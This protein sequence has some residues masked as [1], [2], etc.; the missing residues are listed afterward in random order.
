MYLRGARRVHTCP[1]RPLCEW[2][3]V[4]CK[5]VLARVDEGDYLFAALACRAFRNALWDLHPLKYINNRTIALPRFTTKALALACSHGRLRW[6]HALG[7]SGPMWLQQTW[8]HENGGRIGLEAVCRGESVMALEFVRC[9]VPVSVWLSACELAALGGNLVMLQWARARGAV[10]NIH[11]C[12]NAARSGNLEMLQWARGAGCDWDWHTCARAARG[13][14]L[15]VLQWARGAG[16]DWNSS[17]CSFAAKGGHLEVLQWAR[18]EGCDWNSYT[19]AFAAEGGHLAV[20]Q[21]A[22][23]AGCDWHGSKGWCTTG[24]A[25]GGHLAVLQWARGGG[26]GW[27]HNT[28]M[29][30]AQEGRLEVL[31]WLRS[32][33]MGVCKWNICQCAR[34]AQLGGHLAVVQWIVAEAA[35]AQKTDVAYRRCPRSRCLCCVRHDTHSWNPTTLERVCAGSCLACA[36]AVELVQNNPDLESMILTTLREHRDSNWHGRGR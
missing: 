28:C 25:R 15:A 23:G 21:W 6:A 26:C 14:H 11:T 24:A 2:A 7:R 13:G 19:C 10:W 27:N 5:L 34:A 29:A 16:C 12:A 8:L 4:L 35:V 31:Q 3:H 33:S 17:T 30:A 32:G 36:Y 9:K 20:L 1:P 18:G 22:R